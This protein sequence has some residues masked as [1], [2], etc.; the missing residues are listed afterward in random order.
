MLA[1]ELIVR[2]I[3]HDI[4]VEQLATGA[5]LGQTILEIER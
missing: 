4:L 3:A 1:G 5:E 2:P